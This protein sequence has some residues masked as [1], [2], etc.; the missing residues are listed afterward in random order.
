M[1]QAVHDQGDEAKSYEQR[2]VSHGRDWV[3]SIL[4]AG[5]REA[6]MQPHRWLVARTLDP[7]EHKRTEGEATNRPSPSYL[8]SSQTQAQPEQGHGEVGG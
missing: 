1:I 5:G 4:R 2:L 3:V 6:M 8:W 7:Q